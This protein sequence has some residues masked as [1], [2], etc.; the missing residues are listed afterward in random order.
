MVYFS[1]K[2]QCCI[3]F[4]GMLLAFLF[5][6]QSVEAKWGSISPCSIHLLLAAL[7]RVMPKANPNTAKFS[8][9]HKTIFCEFHHT[10]LW[11]SS[12]PTALQGYWNK[13]A[14]HPFPLWTKKRACFGLVVPLTTPSPVCLQQTVFYYYIGR[15]FLHSAWR[16]A[17]KPGFLSFLMYKWL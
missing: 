15:R 13:C 8:E 16:G 17:K 6:E 14:A 9:H 11:Q 2:L 1:R 7:Q 5:Y 12:S 3:Y 4:L 10:F